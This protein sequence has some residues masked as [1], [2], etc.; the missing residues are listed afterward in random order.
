VQSLVALAQRKESMR[1]ATLGAIA[2]AGLLGLAL[3]GVIVK[4][5]PRM[6]ARTLAQAVAPPTEPPGAFLAEPLVP[7]AATALVAPAP[8]RPA[9]RRAP[10]AKAPKANRERRA[11]T[12]RA[13]PKQGDQVALGP[14]EGLWGGALARC[15]HPAVLDADR[16]LRRAYADA[17]RAGVSRPALVAYRN[18]WASLRSRAGSEPDRL[19]HEYAGMASDLDRMADVARDPRL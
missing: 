19:I 11:A 17:T 3:G 1:P 13:A 12:H 4:A 16:Q 14:C 15:A 9:A 10:S 2:A 18:R 7:L 5:P 8:P 6:D